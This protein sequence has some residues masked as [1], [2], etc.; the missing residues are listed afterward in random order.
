MPVSLAPH[1]RILSRSRSARSDLGLCALR[2]RL[3]GIP[4][5]LPRRGAGIRRP[6]QGMALT[7]WATPPVKQPTRVYSASFVGFLHEGIASADAR[8]TREGARRPLQ[9]TRGIGGAYV[10]FGR[11]FFTKEIG[12]KPLSRLPPDFLFKVVIACQ[13]LTRT[14]RDDRRARVQT[15]ANV[16]SRGRSR[17]HQ[18][19][20]GG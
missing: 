11:H 19:S 6:F 5:L 15:R 9:P 2:G 20:R 3:S 8:T 4:I 17:R 18:I 7:A 14:L 13:G 10:S 12:R 16:S 1:P